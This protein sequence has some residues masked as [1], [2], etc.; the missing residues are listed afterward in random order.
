VNADQ[1]IQ[2]TG[3]DAN[4]YLLGLN[5]WFWIAK[6]DGNTLA[7]VVSTVNAGTRCQ[8][9]DFGG[10]F[11]T[12]LP[13]IPVLDLSWAS[14]KSASTGRPCENTE[15]HLL[16]AA[17]SSSSRCRR[18]VRSCIGDCRPS[19][20]SYGVVVAAVAA[21]AENCSFVSFSAGCFTVRWRIPNSISVTYWCQ[22]RRLL[23]RERWRRGRACNALRRR[24][25]NQETLS[26]TKP[27]NG[28]NPGC[29][30]KKGGQWR[31][32]TSRPRDANFSASVPTANR[33]RPS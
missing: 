13:T 3:K 8:V 26:V 1:S 11:S 6:E 16:D 12:Q 23:I 2:S 21:T 9:P 24:L 15:M 32:L 19:F 4:G 18:P 27:L 17:A 14:T 31:L 29:L 10:R 20:E 30:E 5:I 25:N 22:H 28:T 7:V 33:F